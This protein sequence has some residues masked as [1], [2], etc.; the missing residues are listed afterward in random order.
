M[1]LS[2]LKY[3]SII[4]FVAPIC[5]CSFIPRRIG[6]LLNVNKKD[7]TE[8]SF[9]YSKWDKE[10]NKYIEKTIHLESVTKDSFLKELFNIKTYT[11]NDP[12]KCIGPD[13]YLKLENK[14]I[15]VSDF[16]IVDNSKV[17]YN[18]NPR[19]GARPVGDLINKYAEL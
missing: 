2:A 9:D 6:S 12:C 3:F 11:A 14:E 13:V 17:K 15:I 4:C 10:N 18:L 1:K 5:G 7:V 16:R 19:N 8:V